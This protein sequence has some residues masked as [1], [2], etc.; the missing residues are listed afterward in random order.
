LLDV[1]DDAAPAIPARMLPKLN[2]H[3]RAFWTG[4]ADGRL[5]I[6]QCTRC[7]LWVHPPA[8]DCPDCGGE[9]VARPVSGRGKVFTYTVNYQPFN[10]GVTVPY[11]IAIV[12]LAEHA[13]LRIA[14]NIVDCEPDSV[15]IGLDV[16]VRFERREVDG[17]TVYVPVFAP[18]DPDT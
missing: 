5:L 12:E 13:D 14:T 3:N 8:A 11:V 15:H 1:P 7:A 17:E 6:A 18:Q 4:G 2:D 16:Q 10:P 9:L